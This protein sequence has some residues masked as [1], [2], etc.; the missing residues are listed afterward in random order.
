MFKFYV[1]LFL[2]ALLF[3]S[4]KSLNL[5]DS[6][7]TIFTP[8]KINTYSDELKNNYNEIIEIKFKSGDTKIILR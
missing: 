7:K 2:Y 3:T 8:G 1:I 6:E 5:A 4:T